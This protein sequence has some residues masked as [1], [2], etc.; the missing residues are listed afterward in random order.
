MSTIS[1]PD[2]AMG[3]GC[4]EEP[5][6]ARRNRDWAYSFLWPI[7]HP[8]VNGEAH[9]RDFPHLVGTQGDANFTFFLQLLD[10]LIECR[11]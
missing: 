7:F 10:R 6:E 8:S 2:D 9:P 1:V 11:P 3:G 4:T 5:E